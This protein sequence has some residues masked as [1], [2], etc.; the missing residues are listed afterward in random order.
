[1]LCRGVPNSGKDGIVPLDGMVETDWLPFGF[2]MNWQFTRPGMVSF[3]KDEPFCFIMPVPHLAIEEITPEVKPL[4]AD[5]PLHDEYWAWS[6]SR[7][8]FLAKL[9][10]GDPA[11][12]KEAWQRFYIRGTRDPDGPVPETHRPKR[13]LSKPVEAAE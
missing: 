8:E 12:T 6:R 5:K 11:V 3:M 1:M 2:T 10:A 7:N 4:V 9:A 13:R